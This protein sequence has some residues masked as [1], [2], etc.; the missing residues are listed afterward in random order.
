MRIFLGYPSQ[1][2]FILRDIKILQ[3]KYHVA[4]RK[5]RHW[6]PFRLA[7]DLWSVFR[8]RVI[9]FWFASFY[10]IPT[11]LA[12]VVL[13]KKT[14]VIVG[15][16]EAANLPD[17]GYGQARFTIRKRVLRLILLASDL[18]LAVS[19]SSQKEIVCNLNIPQER[20]KL[21]YH[22]FEDIAAGKLTTKQQ[23]VVSVG[24]LNLETW[25][26]K[27]IEDF[28]R[29]AEQL[30]D[31]PFFYVGKAWFDYEKQWGGPLPQNLTMT[32]QVPFE[33][34][35]DYLAPA[36]VYLQLSRHESFGCSVAEAM[37]FG[38]IPVVSDA[39]ALP[40]VV[41]DSGFVVSTRD[42]E[43]IADTIKQALALPESRGHRCR[44]RILG[45]FSY[46]QRRD[47]LLEHIEN[48]K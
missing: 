48:L 32:G 44:Q 37:L 22:G 8:S 42:S 33:Q 5:I 16:Y 29:V 17:P 19:R 7:G 6:N 46:E 24:N 38:C 47:K 43:K 39:Y 12:A 40:E 27:G 10:I 23:T 11:F 13:G 15:G 30:P 45:H 26:K 3:S 28:F 35:G 14:V 4:A 41:G 21:L 25:L 20:V 18:I 31:I 36:K 2:S 1:A 9:I 34:L